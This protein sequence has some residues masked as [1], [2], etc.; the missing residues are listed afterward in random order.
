MEAFI[1][2]LLGLQ[3]AKGSSDR[4]PNVPGQRLRDL[5][6]SFGRVAE[7]SSKQA[8]VGLLRLTG[9]RLA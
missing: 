6:A 7:C 5:A 9:G 2:P 1:L 8:A 4:N 3:P